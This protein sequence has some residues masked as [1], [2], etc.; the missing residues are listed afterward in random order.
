MNRM[1]AC[2][3]ISAFVTLLV[4]YPLWGQ[5]QG[6]SSS[7][8]PGGSGPGTL[9]RQPGP[10]QPSASPNNRVQG[11]LYVSGRVLLESGQPAPEAVSVE[12]N[13]GMRPLQVIHTDLGGYFTFT[14]GAGVQ[15]NVDFSASNESPMSSGAGRGSSAGGADA[16]LTGCELRVSVPGY[17][18][19]TYTLAD[20]ADMGRIEV[21][22]VQ[23]RRIAGVE[24]SAISVTSLL[25]PASARKEYERAEKE[26]HSNH[27]D[28]ARQHLEKAVAEYD[29]YAAAWN[30]LGRVY[31]SSRQTDK[32][33]QAFEKAAAADPQYIPPFMSLATIQLQS[34]QY[35][36]A[37]ETAGKVLQLDP[38]IAFA[39]FIQA[40]GNFNLNRLEAAEKSAREAEKGAHETFPQVH[41]LLANI[42]LQKQ[43]YSNA[44]IHMRAYLKEAPQG[45]LAE[46]MKKNLEQV[47][48]AA[49]SV[50]S[51]P[52]P[53]AA[54]P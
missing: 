27:L 23:L 9:G 47:E 11:P 34:K 38:S 37:V 46:Q 17:H 13:C 53:A 25:V 51:A 1:F 29:K 40:V 36:S 21:G 42:F 16:S 2:V 33:R 15:S 50:G 43:D 12:I 45:D 18:P 44:A 26:L 19:L 31:S 5:R 41:A 28:P 10:S 4:V 39:S 49:A 14:L 22:T 32:A 48:K 6:S 35:E 30:E 8:V 20:H 3:R 7:S 54:K 24:G 52:D